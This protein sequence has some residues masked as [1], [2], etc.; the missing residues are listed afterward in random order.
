MSTATL[1]GCAV[2]RVVALCLM[3][4]SVQAGPIVFES[5]DTPPY[6][7]PALPDNGIGGSILKLL[8]AEAGVAYSIEYLPVKRFRNSHAAYIVGDPDILVNQ[9]D[10]AIF[11]ISVFRSAF[12]Y[13]KPRRDA[14]DLH[15]LRDL[16][17][18]TLGVLRGTI[19]DMAS[20]TRYDIRVEES[21]SIDSLL[22]K[23]KRGRI[24]VCI[25]VASAGSYK[26]QALFPAERDDFVQVY[27]AGMD[28]PVAVMVD[29][30]SAEGREIA[31]RY[32][33][34]LIKTLHS[35]QYRD[36]LRSYA[37]ALGSYPEEK[38]NDYLRYYANT[39]DTE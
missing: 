8:S 24:D 15:T 1:V 30:D 34:V 39:W 16:R 31:Q 14:V 18:L 21:D 11:P 37:D 22:R 20:F 27:I 12:F 36:L 38:L 13:Y 25:M 3:V 6:W 9:K 26:I 23:L 35:Q 29:L 19:E 17:G 33:Q 7:S 10:R 4:S 2:I 5:T 28:R 32:R